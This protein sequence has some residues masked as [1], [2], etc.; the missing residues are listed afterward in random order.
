MS[1]DV[2]I[3]RKISFVGCILIIPAIELSKISRSLFMALQWRRR[4][5]SSS[6]SFDSHLVDIRWFIGVIGL[7]NRPLSIFKSCELI[8]YLAIAVMRWFPF[9][10]KM[11]GS[12]HKDFFTN[13]YVR[14][15]PSSGVNMVQRRAVNKMY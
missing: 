3:R 11:Y 6:I 2:I 10:F 4:C 9:M 8:L 15:V 14:L 5:I 7:L 13:E 1:L 12:T